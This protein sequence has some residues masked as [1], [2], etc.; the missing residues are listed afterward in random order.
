MCF[1]NGPDVLPLFK[2]DNR[3]IFNKHQFCINVQRRQKLQQLPI[4][5]LLVGRYALHSLEYGF[6]FRRVGKGRN[7]S[8]DKRPWTLG[9]LEKGFCV[10]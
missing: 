2:I 4:F 10:G 8:D 7:G 5:Y 9:S 1:K 3:E 6:V